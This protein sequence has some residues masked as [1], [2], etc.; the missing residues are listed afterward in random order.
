MEYALDCECG[1]KLIVRETAAGATEQCRC[2]RTIVVP[3]LHNLRRMAGLP[4]PGLTPEKAVETLLLA[5]KL[6]QE[7]HCVVCGDA[8]D[9]SIC[10]KTEC[11]RAYVESGRP[12]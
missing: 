11:E 1:E 6:P 8:T 7:K 3:S 4:E 2:G 5:G 9:D 10:C 12:S